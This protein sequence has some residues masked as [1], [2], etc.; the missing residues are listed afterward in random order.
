MS[1][2]SEDR[3]VA[4]GALMLHFPTPQTSTEF[5]LALSQSLP[6]GQAGKGDGPLVVR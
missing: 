1:A 5:P 3:S 4:D 2:R 6:D